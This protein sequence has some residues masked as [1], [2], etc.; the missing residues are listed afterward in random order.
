MDI[1]KYSSF[2]FF[3][4]IDFK[5]WVP[6]TPLSSLN[7]IPISCIKNLDSAIISWNVACFI[8]K[9]SMCWQYPLLLLFINYDG[10]FCFCNCEFA[11]TA[12][13]RLLLYPSFTPPIAVMIS[14]PQMGESVLRW[15]L[16]IPTSTI[17]WLGVPHH[18]QKESRYTWLWKVISHIISL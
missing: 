1:L 5:F 6:R 13:S 10:S 2:H 3:L 16:G 11:A 9:C 15:Q 14:S 18:L 17:L 12:A 4:D 7:L 8:G